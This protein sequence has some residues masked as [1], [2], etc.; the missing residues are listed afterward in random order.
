MDW[1]MLDVM[2]E[3]WKNLDG[4]THYLWSVW[5]N[6][7]RVHMGGTHKTPD[8]AEREARDYC[9]ERLGAEP[10]SVTRL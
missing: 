3:E 2:I 6:G 10:K 9:T 4:S 5:R 1:A 8:A 7:Q